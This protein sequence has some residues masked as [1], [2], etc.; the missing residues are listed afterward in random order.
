VSIAKETRTVANL[1]PLSTSVDIGTLATYCGEQL[2]DVLGAIIVR[3]VKLARA[4][5]NR[6]DR[7][8]RV[9]HRIHDDLIDRMFEGQAN[10]LPA[11]SLLSVAHHLE[12]VGDRVTNLAEDLVFLDS[13]DLV[14]LG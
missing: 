13:G 4:V 1:P 8:D 10:I 11:V 5:A 12:R 7:L 3:D 14:E 2:R 9:Y 6:D